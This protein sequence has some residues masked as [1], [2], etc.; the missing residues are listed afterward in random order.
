MQ[1]QPARGIGFGAVLPIADNRMTKRGELNPDLILAPGFELK[2]E[3]RSLRMLLEHPIVRYR[4][5]ATL[6]DPTYPQRLV[7]EQTISQG[8]R[9]ARRRALDH[10]EIFF[11]NIFPVL[12]H[13]SL[14]AF[15]SREQH[16]PGGFAIEAV[17]YKSL[18]RQRLG[19]RLQVLV[20]NAMRGALLL[21]RG[22]HRKQS[23]RFV[24]YN[25]GLV[26]VNDSEPVQRNVGVGWSL[27]G[28]DSHEVARFQLRI[29]P[30]ILPMQ[31]RHRAKSQHPFRF[32]ARETR[33]RP[34]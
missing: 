7:F 32:S 31:H 18:L 21:A 33:R 15:A 23:G 30:H 20:E 26:E 25:H 22:A 6:L 10:R 3:D 11:R 12:L 1:H 27:P 16:Q 34:E 29:V 8:S 24:N 2:L 13:R 14:D 28:R 4:E 5:L 19:L 9:R 17:D